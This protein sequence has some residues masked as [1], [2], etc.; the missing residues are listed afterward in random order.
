MQWSDEGV[1][2]SARRHG[3]SALIVQL[4]THE[5]GRHAGLARGQGPKTR[6]IYQIGNQ[7]AVTWRA[8]LIEHLGSLTGEVVRSHAGALLDDPLRLA[9]LVAAAA[10]AEAA[11]PEREPHPRV[12]EGLLAVIDALEA[13]SGWA[14]ALV[15]WEES[16]LAELGFGLDLS[17]CAATGGTED[18]IYV[19]PRSGQA[20]SAA[21]GEAYR[22]RLLRLPSFLLPGE[23]SRKPAPAEVLDGI[24]LT[25]FFLERRVFA[26][27]GRKMPAARSRFV[28]V[29]RQAVTISGG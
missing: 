5:H 9:C 12:Y 17:R 6:A 4:L 22:E 7:L 10:V 26:P 29:L 8:R 25:G 21:A 27:H 19:S 20:V 15:E 16:L 18:L 13:D 14:V 1:V 11:L 2:L 24:E 23:P 3:E 28:D